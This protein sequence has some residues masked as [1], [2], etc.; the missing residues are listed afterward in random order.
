MHLCY[1]ERLRVLGIFNLEERRL[2]GDRLNTCKYLK[3]K[4]Q[5]DRARQLE[6]GQC[7]QTGR[8]EFPC[9]H[10]RKLLYYKSDRALQQA[11]QKGCGLYIQNPPGHIPGQ[12]ISR[13]AGGTDFSRVLF[14]SLRFCN[15]VKQQHGLETELFS[16]FQ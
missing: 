15:S 16:S 10:E 4:C 12:L 9:E 7:A 5:V 2:R 14:K 11:V 8:Q 6:K 13:A 1:E 3:G